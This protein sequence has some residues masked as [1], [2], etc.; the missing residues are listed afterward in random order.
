MHQGWTAKRSAERTRGDRAVS[1]NIRWGWP[2][3]VNGDS[4]T[5]LQWYAAAGGLRDQ[6][7]A[8]AR[9]VPNAGGAVYSAAAG[10]AAA[11]LQLGATRSLVVPGPASA[12]VINVS[13]VGGNSYRISDINAN[14][15]TFI[16]PYLPIPFLFLEC[17]VNDIVMGTDPAT[18]LATYGAFLDRVKGDSP[19]VQ[20]LCMG[21][22]CNGEQW[23]T[24]PN[25]YSS[26][27]A[28][29]HPIE[30]NIAACCAARPGWTE[31]AP[32][33]DWSLA[34]QVAN[35]T[36]SPGVNSGILT[37]DGVHPNTTGQV[38]MGTHA[39]DHL[40]FSV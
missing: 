25:R 19:A 22:L 37:L 39:M 40:T 12:P 2:V 8:A 26:G 9:L 30:Q 17:S 38:L 29:T 23:L 15:A 31:Y 36:P 21:A 13:A 16:T 3:L 33:C 18:H 20:I 4:I 1:L 5:V 6:M 7:N 28:L 10:P 11:Q 35:N 34:Y 24:G 14:Y 27:L 32:Q